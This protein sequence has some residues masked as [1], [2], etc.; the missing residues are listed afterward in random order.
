M[1]VDM[2]RNDLGR[3]A[4][5]GSVR[6]ES[7]FATQRHPTLWQMTSSVS[8]QV[9]SSLT[10]IFSALFPAASITGA[11]KARTMELIRELEYGPRR[12][13]TGS[14]GFLLPDGRAQF[15]VA[16]RTLLHD[17][18]RRRLEYGVG[19]G[20]VADSSIDGEWEETRTKSLAVKPLVAEFSLLETMRWRPGEGIFL[21]ERHLHRLR[22]SAEYFSYPCDLGGIRDQLAKAVANLP[23]KGCKL[24]LLLDRFGR[25]SVK[26][27]VLPTRTG[28]ASLRLVAAKSPVESNDPFLYH[29]TTRRQV[30]E[31]A[32]AAAPRQ[33]DDV[34]LYNHKG[35]L[36]ETTIA[37]IVLVL[38]GRRCTPPVRCGLLAGTLRQQLLESGDIEERCLKVEDLE[39]A[40]SIVLIN[41]VRGEMAAVL[42]GNDRA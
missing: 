41:S 11:P 21:L 16:I 14:I 26:G 24:R 3:I 29:K 23:A 39:H 25:V 32:R 20:I 22:N 42:W 33:A 2:V 19:G 12:I 36:T 8:G 6:V 5:P 17:R 34:I 1:I 31:Q 28:S 15:N 30:Y 40:D 35:E 13:Y 18:R 27:E 4:V 37:N 38:G 9:R 10:D 7:L